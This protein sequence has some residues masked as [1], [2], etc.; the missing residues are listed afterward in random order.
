MNPVFAFRNWVIVMVLF[1]TRNDQKNLFG[2]YS[3]QWSPIIP[4][5][6]Y[7]HP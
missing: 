2:S 4:A 3:L 7:T 5:S 1:K 6:L